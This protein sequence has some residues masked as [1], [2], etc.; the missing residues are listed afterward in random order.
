MNLPAHQSKTEILVPPTTP[1]STPSFANLR[2]HLG[3]VG[4]RPALMGG[5]TI[6]AKGQ[7]ALRENAAKLK[8]RLSAGPADQEAI[9]AELALLLMAFP[10]Q[11]PGIGVQVVA[12]A[13]REALF[14]AP[15]WAV[16]VARLRIIRGE[17]PNISQAFAPSPPA[18]ASVVR[19][20]LRPLRE[21]LGDLEALA[22]IDAADDP[23]TKAR[24]SE[25]F[26]MLRDELL[27]AAKDTRRPGADAAMDR[28][29][30]RA[31]ANGVDVET[32]LSA[33]PDAKPPPGWSQAAATAE[34]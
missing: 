13:Y 21:D 6:S 11:D 17:I 28:L 12:R 33:I 5:M 26:D 20:V 24:V 34:G 1:F 31:K 22:S 25:G 27:P 8:A 30:A 32:A 3:T 16:H 15:A 29:R 4:G 18:F 19:D 9:A 14:D 7:Q 23:A 10:R 2:R